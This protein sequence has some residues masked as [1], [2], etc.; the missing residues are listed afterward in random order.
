MHTGNNNK[1]YQYYKTREILWQKS[2]GE[3]AK[4][5]LQSDQLFHHR[6]ESNACSLQ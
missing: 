4:L 1:R 2:R 3:N 6:G 5:V